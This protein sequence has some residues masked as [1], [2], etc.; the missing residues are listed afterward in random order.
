M[1]THP[2]GG[3]GL[4]SLRKQAKRWL[5]AIREGDAL[6][7][8]RLARALERELSRPG[9][10][11]VQLGLAR[12][13]GYAGWTALTQAVE[14]SRPAGDP[15]PEGEAVL[16]R[17]QDM[18]DALLEAYRTGT[19]EAMARHYAY[20][21]HRRAWSTMRT[22][23]QLDLGKRPEHE[24]DDVEITLDDA[25][26]LV[27]LEY[28]FSGWEELRA[29]SLGVRDQV[30][31][32]APKPVAVTSGAQPSSRI[33]EQTREWS[34]VIDLLAQAQAEGLD[35][36]GQMTDAVL[37]R[38]A[39]ISSL[40]E[41]SL[42]TSTGVTDLGLRHLARLPRLR[43]LDL[44]W[45][46]VTDRGLEALAQLPRL[47]SVNLSFTRVTDLGVA[48]LA[49]CQ[50]LR[51]VDL[52]NTETGDG[53]LQ[54]LAGKPHLGTLH[55]GNRITDQ[56]L[57][58]LR[59]F[60][61]F[62][63]WQG[64]EGEIGPLSPN[65]RPNQLALRGPISDA[66]LGALEGLD[67][68]FA[69]G[70]E[71]EDMSFT[72][73]GIDH[74]TALPR[75]TWLAI[76]ATDDRMAAIARLPH[77]RYLGCQDTVAGDEGFTA[78]SRSASV[79]TIWGRRCHN[80]RTAGFIALAAMPSLRELSV[81]CLNVEDRGIAVLPSF[82]ALR[83]LMPMDVPDDGYRHIGRCSS[84]EVLTLMYCRA[85]GDGATGHLTGLPRLRRYFA[86]YTNITDRTPELLSGI[87]SLEE[88]EI[89]GCPGLTDAGVVRLARLPRLRELKISGQHVSSAVVEAFPPGVRVRW[90]A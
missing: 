23:V 80:L 61:V 32:I 3:R 21:W 65:A 22:Y 35:A 66:G 73:R 75:L 26:K 55:C 57:R 60:P 83:N 86:S 90:E 8:A 79:E 6:A 77:L 67:G 44:S 72:P 46:A 64:G 85:T 63:S 10:R 54:A 12:E 48:H 81:S 43:H 15:T 62:R 38:L 70:L 71:G 76:T 53:S 88:I 29:F 69:L 42:S 2:T 45:T 87:D 68:L 39:G 59:E 40:Q 17:Y 25:R 34:R 13:L 84:L 56:G 27:A 37:E 9:L 7:R 19:P 50:S 20:T 14:T 47:E 36:R 41:L 58:L 18:A 28:G 74:L 82:P 52:N 16:A 30:A 33:V 78:L 89:Y 24:G 5:K 31:N 11:D 4:E 49:R 1:G 51:R